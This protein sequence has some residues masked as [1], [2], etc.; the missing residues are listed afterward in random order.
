MK[1]NMK[2]KKM[3]QA[4][5]LKVAQCAFNIEVVE[6]HRR[7][8]LSDK[9]LSLSFLKKKSVERERDFGK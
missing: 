8:K 9:C 7:E 5:C 3:F 2:M 6:T 4:D 1:L